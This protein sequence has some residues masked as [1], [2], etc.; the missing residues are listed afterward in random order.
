MADE[1]IQKKSIKPPLLLKQ[2][3]LLAEEV[4]KYPCLYNKADK[5]YKEHDVIRNA[6][7]SV[8]FALEFVDDGMFKYSILSISESQ[9]HK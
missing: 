1:N 8:L 5:S 2:E 3:E 7:E 9:F 6:W 4:R